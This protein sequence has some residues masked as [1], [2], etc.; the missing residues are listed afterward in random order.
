MSETPEIVLH[1]YAP[2][3]FAEVIRLS[4]GLKGLSWKSVE[5]PNVSPKPGLT[6]LTGGYEHI[7]VLQIGADIYCDTAVIIDAL[8]AHRPAPSLY[9][10]P[11]GFAGRMIALWSGGMWFMPSV[12][13]ALGPVHESLP[14]EFWEDR[15]KRFGMD[16]ATFLPAVPH[17][18]TQFAG[19]ANLLRE[20]LSDG[21]AF[22][23]GDQAGHADFALYMNIRFVGFAGRKPSDF[24]TEIAA[25]Y[26][27]VTAIGHGE[28]QD[29][30]AEQAIEH[31]AG[32]TPCADS[33]V[34]P[35]GGYAAGDQVSIRTASPDPAAVTGTLIG[36]DDRRI[37]IARDDAQ[38]GRVHVHFPRLGQVMTRA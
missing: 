19:G 12:A 18:Q 23:V 32:I 21:R 22:I 28:R 31:A 37:S 16:P 4:L 33:A 24:G 7:P 3:P 10:A 26:D 1:H 15:K 9:P 13:T 6:A 5:A 36:C 38:A 34:A 20:A 8:E 17:M 2:S 35:D 27:R 25:W 11:L 29:W 30:T 14:Q